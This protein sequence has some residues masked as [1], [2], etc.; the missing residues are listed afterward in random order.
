MSIAID[1][2][3]VLSEENMEAALRYLQ[4]KNDSCGLDGVRLSELPEYYRINKERI[5]DEV[6][7]GSYKPGPV[8]CREIVTSNRKRRVIATMNSV[9]RL[10][11]RVLAQALTEAVDPY[12]SASSYAYRAGHGTEN[13]VA[14]AAVYMEEGYSWVCE[15]DVKSFFDSIPHDPLMVRVESIFEGGVITGLIE[16]FIRCKR[17]ED[18]IFHD[19][20]TGLIQGS[21]LSPVLSNLY[22]D[23]LDKWLEQN[24]VHFYRYGDDINVYV[25]T[26]EEAF[27]IRNEITAFLGKLGL[28]INKDKGGVFL[29]KNRNCLRYGFEEKNGKIYAQKIIKTQK[30]IYHRWQRSA[31]KKVDRKYHIVSDGILSRK[32]FTILFENEEGK[33]YLPAEAMDCL[34][35]YASMTLSSSFFEYANKVGLTLAFFDRSGEKIGSFLPRKQHRSY[36]IEVE[37]IKLMQNE[38]MHLKIAKKYQNANI[39]NLRAILRYYERRGHD[40]FL[41]DSIGKMTEILQKV[42]E[43]KDVN[44]LMMY[45]AQAR[46]VYYQCFRVILQEEGFEFRRRTRRPPKDPLNAMISFGNTILYQRFASLIYRSSL[47]IRFGLLHNSVHR[48]ESLNLDLA[49]LFKPVLVDRTIFTLVNRKMLRVETDFQEM[50]NGAVYLNNRGKKLFLIEFEKKLSQDVK[51]KDTKKNYE[52]LMQEEV[53]KLELFFRNGEVYK[54]Y[55]YVN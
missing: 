46:Q 23:T 14:Q 6:R 36:R 35:I 21:P 52:D 7:F 39:F 12:L 28:H 32:D 48:T 31:I 20:E 4:N 3:R 8:S 43:V 9:D 27:L 15:L 22:L 13:A 18:G 37:Q 44:A 1:L 5:I 26:S 30:Q 54:P 40:P 50:E 2:E 47:D 29:G 45:E 11:G 42:N 49:D 51:C 16:R 41:Q 10:I 25:K 19:Q 38:S 17:E 34:N 55:K 33:R 53:R 24:G